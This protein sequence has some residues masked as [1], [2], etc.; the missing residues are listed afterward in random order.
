LNIIYLR[1]RHHQYHLFS[2][3]I[4]REGRQESKSESTYDLIREEGKN[5]RFVGRSRVASPT[6]SFFKRGRE[7][8]GSERK[9]VRTAIVTEKEGWRKKTARGKDR[10]GAR[11]DA[12]GGIKTRIF[13]YSW[14]NKK[15]KNPNC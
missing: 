3:I 14:K 4:S 1:L 15:T 13:K 8:L 7:G 2:G 5:T 6:S 10:K 11:G 12:S 9:R